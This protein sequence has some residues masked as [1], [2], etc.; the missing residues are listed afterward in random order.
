MAFVSTRME[1]WGSW[2]RR[3]YAFVWRVKG[4]CFPKSALGEYSSSRTQ[5][6]STKNQLEETSEVNSLE[7]VIC[8]YAVHGWWLTRVWVA[9][10]LNVPISEERQF[11]LC[12]SQDSKDL[13]VGCWEYKGVSLF[14]V[15]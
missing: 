6:Y 4:L 13:P 3:N 2:N 9:T 1:R 7:T 10:K 5:D 11:E 12:P 15:Q 14:G 8:S